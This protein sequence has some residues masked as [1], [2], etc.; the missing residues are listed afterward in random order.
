[1]KTLKLPSGLR[2][3]ASRGNVSTDLSAFVMVNTAVADAPGNR[4]VSPAVL[5]SRKRKERLTLRE[6]L[7]IIELA[8]TGVVQR[9]CE[10]AKMF[11]KSR[12]TISK[13]LRPENVAHTKAMALAGHKLEARRLSRPVPDD[14]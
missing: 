11:Q 2:S 12:M 6:K 14:E 5:C 10:L 7:R 4:V 9:Q 1:M 8:E 3:S 13:L